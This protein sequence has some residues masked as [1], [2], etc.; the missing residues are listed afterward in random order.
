MKWNIKV[1]RVSWL[2]ECVRREGLVHFFVV[3]ELSNEDIEF[4]HE[5]EY[6][7][8]KDGNSDKGQISGQIDKLLEELERNMCN[9][10]EELGEEQ[11]LPLS[12]KRVYLLGFP[13]KSSRY[14][15][16]W[17]AVRALRLL[18]KYYIHVKWTHLIRIEGATRSLKK[19]SSV[20]YVLV[21]PCTQSGLD[22]DYY[23]LLLLLM[24][25]YREVTQVKRLTVPQT[26]FLSVFTF[27]VVFYCFIY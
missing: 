20:S 12:Q 19:D 27:F 18:G 3:Y 8:K 2:H 11:E 1:V 21:H 26:K 25:C 6:L 15:T 10:E 23:V 9:L 5:N 16:K 13:D 24:L 22:V 14:M 7:V 4:V 17:H